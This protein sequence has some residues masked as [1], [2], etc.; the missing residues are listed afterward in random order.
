MYI[1]ETFREERVDSEGLQ[2]RTM[3]DLH[4]NYQLATLVVDDQGTKGSATIGKGVR[5]ALPEVG[6]VD[7]GDVLL[8][9][10]ALSHSNDRAILNIKNS[11]LSEDWA[12][13]GLQHDTGARIGDDSRLL[14]QLLGEQIDTQVAV[15]TSGRGGGDLDQLTRTTLKDKDVAEADEVGGNGDGIGSARHLSDW[16]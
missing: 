1:R 3:D 8:D 15:L 14:P 13:H 11:V 5:E 9:I 2:G 10:A 6:L 7:H 16:S 12:K 4:V